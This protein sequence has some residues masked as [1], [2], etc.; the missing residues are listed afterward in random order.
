VGHFGQQLDGFG[1]EERCLVSGGD[2]PDQ[3]ASFALDHG[4]GG[5]AHQLVGGDAYSEW[6]A[7][8]LAGLAS[9]AVG[10]IYRWA[11][12]PFGAGDVEIGVAPVAGFYEW[13]EAGQD[14]VQGPVGPG[15]TAGVG[16]PDDQIGADPP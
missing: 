16:W 6:Q 1:C 11:E 12:Q 9:D 15:P 4:G 3:G 2:R 8:R 13:S 7:Q 10:D 14:T 5:G